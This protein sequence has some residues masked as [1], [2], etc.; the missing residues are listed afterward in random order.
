MPE[1]MTSLIEPMQIL[2]DVIPAAT[3]S[4]LSS[5]VIGAAVII[6]FLDRIISIFTNLKRN[7]VDVMPKSELIKELQRLEKKVD[8]VHNERR[9][10]SK[11]LFDKVEQLSHSIANSLSDF[12]RALGRLEGGQEIALSIRATL[13]SLVE[14]SQQK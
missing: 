5:L 11:E 10:V 9:E 12:S 13:S 14:N 2:A 8:E 7:Q 3:P 1:N 4:A 6:Y